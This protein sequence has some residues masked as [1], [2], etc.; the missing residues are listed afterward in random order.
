MRA[1]KFLT[2]SAQSQLSY[3]QEIFL[4]FD[5]I[6]PLALAIRI[7]TQLDDKIISISTLSCKIWT[8]IYWISASKLWPELVKIKLFFLLSDYWWRMEVVDKSIYIMYESETLSLFVSGWILEYLLYFCCGVITLLCYKRSQTVYNNSITGN[9]SRCNYNRRLCDITQLVRWN[10]Q[11]AKPDLL[12]IS[13]K[14][15]NNEVSW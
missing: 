12:L 8:I 4:A 3:E 9:V 11:A 10:T 13:I 7:T 1:L 15:L 5:L 14:I 6:T 2:S